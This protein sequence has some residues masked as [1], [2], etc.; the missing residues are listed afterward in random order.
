MIGGMTVAAAALARELGDLLLGGNWGA[1]K[2]SAW[3]LVSTSLN[4]VNE[5]G[6]LLV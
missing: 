2:F 6:G 5:G 3:F 4:A 1:V